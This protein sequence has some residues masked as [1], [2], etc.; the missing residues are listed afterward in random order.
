MDEKRLQE[1]TDR[2]ESL[3]RRQDKFYEWAGVL[4]KEYRSMQQ[5]MQFL[6]S[7]R[8]LDLG[9]G[10][11]ENALLDRLDR[12]TRDRPGERHGPVHDALQ[13]H[14]GHPQQPLEKVAPDALPVH[15]EDGLHGT[16]DAQH[17]RV[18]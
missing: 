18:V 5:R 15:R 14:R 13:Q 1:F 2:L 8:D 4:Q 12:I 17:P 16:V 9:Q 7:Q 3:H 11:Q 10:A 6:E